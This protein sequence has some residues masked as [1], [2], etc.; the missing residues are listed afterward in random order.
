METLEQPPK[1]PLE[2]A[3]EGPTVT[4]PDPVEPSPPVAAVK[5]LHV[6]DPVQVQEPADAIDIAGALLDQLHALPADPFRILLFRARYSHGA[7]D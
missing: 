7:A 1:L 6:A 3:T 4:C 2:M 5:P